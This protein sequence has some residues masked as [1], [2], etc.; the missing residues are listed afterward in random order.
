MGRRFGGFRAAPNLI[1]GADGLRGRGRFGMARRAQHEA[2]DPAP[3]RQ[4]CGPRFR[5]GDGKDVHG[6]P[7][8]GVGKP[9][10]SGIVRKSMR[11]GLCR[12]LSTSLNPAL[13]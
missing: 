9:R 10:A 5:L 12:T 13:G 2:L 3:G 8:G 7:D 4:A 6:K 11:P 1:L